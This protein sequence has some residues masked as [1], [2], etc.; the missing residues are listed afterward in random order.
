MPLPG[1]LAT[2]IELVLSEVRSVSKL[3]VSDAL[4][5]VI[6]DDPV[7]LT[8]SDAPATLVVSDAPAVLVSDGPAVLTASTGSVL[9][10]H[11]VTS[12]RCKRL[13]SLLSLVAINYTVIITI[14]T[15]YRPIFGE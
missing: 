13:P 8:V 15:L 5:L 3:G 10:S 4:V 6:S 7:V 12:Y 11:S 14:T 9:Y 1:E 2:E